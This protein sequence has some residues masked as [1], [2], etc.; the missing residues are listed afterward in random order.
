MSLSK[1]FKLHLL[2]FFIAFM[3]RAQ[4]ESLWPNTE[5]ADKAIIT[6]M[7]ASG[8]NK[9]DSAV[10]ICPGGGYAGVALKHEGTNIGKWFNDHGVTAIVLDYRVSKKGFSHPA[11]MDDVT[12]AM[13]IVRSRAEELGI[14]K[15]KIGVMG[16]SAGGHLASTLGT[17]FDEGNK[18]ATDL[19]ERE[20]SRPNFM[21]LCYPVIAFGESFTHKGSQRNLLGKDA[22][23]EL[24]KKFSNEKQVKPN[25]PPTFL[26]HCDNDKG[27]PPQNSIAFY[28]AL[29]E[30]GI[31][32]ELH[33]YQ[34]GGHGKGLA[35][36]IPGTREWSNTLANWLRI[37]GIIAN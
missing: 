18:D 19:V 32:A 22:S 37:R 31:P 6:I 30:K 17:H 13:R 27:V 4:E 26:F 3:A 33:I 34:N 16:F 29:K 23:D 36:K 20:S 24:I 12:R 10:L 28:L 21:I 5:Y 14:D 2:V 11:P 15:D 1:L 9:T 8:E 25:T 7:K 35:H